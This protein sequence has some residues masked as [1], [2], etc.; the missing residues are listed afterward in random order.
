MFNC[1]VDEICVA[2][3]ATQG[4]TVVKLNG[5]DYIVSATKV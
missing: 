3:R 2:G 4:V 5:G 1:S